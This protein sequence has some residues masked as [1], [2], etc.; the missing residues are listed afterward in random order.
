MIVSEAF[1]RSWFALQRQLISGLQFAYVE[2]HGAGVPAAGLTVTHPENYVSPSEVSLA[3]RLARQSG[4]PITGVCKSKDDGT[5]MLRI[6]CPL[7]LGQDANGAMVVEVDASLDKQGAVLE[8]LTWG[9]AWMNLALSQREEEPGSDGYKRL[10]DAGMSQA[11]YRDTITVILALLRIRTA[12]T[13]VALGRASDG[14]ARLEAVSELSVL[15]RR[16]ARV[17]MVESAMNEAL[18]SGSTVYCAT[19]V[20]DT[21]DLS[22]HHRLVEVAGLASVCSV[23][24]LIGRRNSLVFCFEFA[25]GAGEESRVRAACE[26]GA[27]ILAPLLEL[28]HE[29]QRPW[30]HRL[31]A[32]LR[33]G[34]SQLTDVHG[35]R[36]RIGLLATTVLFV[37]FLLSSGEYRV[38]ASATLEG[39][40]QRAVVA[41]FDGYIFDAPVRAGHEVAEGELLARLDN[42]ELLGEQRR[43]LAEQAEFAE[44]HSQAIAILDHGKAKIHD[45]QLEQARARLSLV[46]AQLSRTVLSAPLGGLV[47]SG[48]WSRSLGVPVQRGELLFQ[49]A[50]LDEYQVVMRVGDR[51]IAGLAVGQA[52]ELT[53]S[54]LPR[55]TVRFTVSGISTMAPEEPGEPTF[56]VE[57]TLSDTLQDMRPGMHGV[58]KISVGIR[59]RWWIWTHS[60]TD[61]LRLQL[62]RIW[63]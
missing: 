43:L 63:P 23:P 9:E 26:E 1:I 49:I 44:Q 20:V 58:A 57:A 35:R 24:L 25:D 28:H 47:I 39:T 53:L 50:P 29:V 18:Y 51:D 42:R 48:D 13:R 33:E 7:K 59:R 38:P 56:R 45:A 27:T 30:F 11:D 41:P 22:Q 61:S 3:A 16:S 8:L 19:A 54:A 14:K 62:W 46:K 5:S 31:S 40:V 60:L 34:M 17:K 2:L 52:G 4:A 10:I 36:W 15:D 37:F 32:L 6:A 21:V 12:C 55:Q